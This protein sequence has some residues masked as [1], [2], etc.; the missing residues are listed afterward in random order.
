M[1]EKKTRHIQ[2]YVRFKN[3][4]DL[5]ALKKLQPRAH[6]EGAKGSDDENHKY[7]SKEGDFRSN[8]T[9]KLTREDLL[10]M[11]AKSY[12][13]VI[14]KPWQRSVLDLLDSCTNPRTIHWIYE[15]TGNVGKTFLA[16]FLCLRPGT[17]ICQGKSADVLNQVN[18]AIDAGRRPQLILVDI[19]RVTLDYV[20]YNCLE[21]LKNGLLYSGKYEGGVCIFPS[22]TVLC[23]A[24]EMP[25]LHKMSID[26][27]DI[28]IIKDNQLFK[29]IL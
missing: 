19:P 18:V 29:K 13:S 20:S 22:P 25:Q 10:A 6:F 15:S 4:K 3:Q 7:C 9:P 1:G 5:S 16:K 21:C 23:F 12:E 11:V 17:I 14:W 26:R 27:W 24:N 2:G 8:Y 28:H